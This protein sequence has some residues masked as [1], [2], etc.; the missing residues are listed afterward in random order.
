[1]IR[2]AKSLLVLLIAVG[3]RAVPISAQTAPADPVA[4][5]VRRAF[6]DYQQRLNRGDYAGA[7]EYY[8][9]DPRF[10]WVTHDKIVARSKAEIVKGYAQLKG[11]GARI[12]Y[13]IPRIT[14]LSP[15][16]AVIT[17]T[18][19]ARMGKGPKATQFSSLLTLVLIRTE[20]GWRFLTGRA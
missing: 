2:L 1:M 14:V 20:A 12:T 6:D 18:L 19:S 9:D 16:A 15:D 13:A 11:S 10:F 5:G 3:V 4:E 17:T 7:L 8:A